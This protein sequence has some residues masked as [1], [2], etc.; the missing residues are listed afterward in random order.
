MNSAGGQ[1]IGSILYVDNTA[2][3]TWH[4]NTTPRATVCVAG[5]G[6]LCARSRPD[7]DRRTHAEQLPGV[8]RGHL[9]PGAALADELHDHGYRP[10]PGICTAAGCRASIWMGGS[11][12]GVPTGTLTLSGTT[13]YGSPGS[14]IGY[15]TTTNTGAVSINLTNSHLDANAYA[16]FWIGGN[17]NAALSIDV[18]ATGTTFRAT[19]CPAS[20]PR[21]SATISI[22]GGAISNNGSGAGALSQTPGG[23]VM[24]DS[25]SAN[26][27]TMRNVTMADNSGSALTSPGPR[28]PRSTSA[29]RRPRGATSSPESRSGSLGGEPL[30]PHRRN[31][32]RQYVDAGRARAPT[33]AGHYT[34]RRQSPG[35][36]WA[37][38]DR[39]V[40][41]ECGHAVSGSKWQ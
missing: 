16:G 25:A 38:R 26:S 40:G 20:P 11:Q 19:P 35:P 7:R 31:R 21:R 23:I 4:A 34:T 1:D 41:G 32:R 15:S 22:T 9:R 8:R 27:L 17:T 24:H 6:P 36:P 14:A 30:G 28:A 12:T 29:P 2:S 39:P 37:Q 10:G 13:I 33:R 3:V 18:T 5:P